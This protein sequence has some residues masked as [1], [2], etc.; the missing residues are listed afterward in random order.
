[1]NLCFTEAIREK[2]FAM[3]RDKTLL[4]DEQWTIIEPLLPPPKGSRRG[5]PKPLPNRPVFEGI[6]WVLR[7]GARWKDLPQEYPSPSTCW[8][9]LRA[10]EETGVWEQA[11]RTLLAQLDQQQHLGW[12]EVFTDATFSPAKK[13]VPR[14]AKPN[15]E[16][17]RSLWWWRTA[18]VYL[19]QCTSPLRPQRK[20]SSSRKRS[21]R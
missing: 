12:E 3:A 6:L 13:G 11:W 8:R 4:T 2:D 16:K 17:V 18:R 19:W 9:R 15:V 1:M 21:P 7:S 5:G 14:W 10:W 20:S